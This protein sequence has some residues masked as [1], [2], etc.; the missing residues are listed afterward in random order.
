MN[1]EEQIK[2]LQE[3]M[4]TFIGTKVIRAVKMN[5]QE[6]NDLRGCTVPSDENPEDEGYLVEYQ[7]DSQTNVEGFDGYISWSPTKPFMEAYHL[8]ET[9]VDRLIIEMRDLQEKIEKLTKFI[10]KGKPEFM[11]EK[12]FDL[13]ISQRHFM[14]QY[15]SILEMRHHDLCPPIMDSR[16][17]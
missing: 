17:E 11:S 15:M 3:Q 10:H 9:H 13:L 8:A 1:R 16:P 6:Y 12:H 4:R 5:R 14:L 2:T 7:N